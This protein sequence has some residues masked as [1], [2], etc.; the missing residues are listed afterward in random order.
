MG[1]KKV[2]A[3]AAAAPATTGS[4]P[5][6]PAVAA[7]LATA[8]FSKVHYLSC[9]PLQ[10]TGILFSLLNAAQST[11]HASSPSFSS[12]GLLLDALIDR[13]LQFLPRALA[14]VLVAQ[15][16]A[17][18]T[19]RNMRRTSQAVGKKSEEVEGKRGTLRGI[20]KGGSASTDSLKAAIKGY[21]FDVRRALQVE[22]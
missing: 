6:R 7:K 15:V 8:P 2:K 10:L 19:L 5:T 4:T 9:V 11:R 18:I 20:A 22:N 12:P 14:G 17:G 3:A 13:P 1:K 21:S 16:Y